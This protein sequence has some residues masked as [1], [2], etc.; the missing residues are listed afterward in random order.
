VLLELRRTK[1]DSLL[2]AGDLDAAVTELRELW[3]EVVAAPIDHDRIRP[4]A[5]ID[6]VWV[7]IILGLDAEVSSLAD[8]LCG[9]P[10]GEVAGWCAR[11][12]V[13]ARAHG[14]A[15]SASHLLRAA[16]ASTAQGVPLVDNDVTVVA[17]VRALELGEAERACRLLACL[18]GGARSPGSYQ[19]LRHA[20]ERVRARLDH[21]VIAGIRAETR[22]EDPSVI[23]GA[24]LRRL[25]A[26]M[27]DEIRRSPPCAPSG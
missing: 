19:L 14:R 18:A 3:A 15:A 16:A 5:G 4:L 26:E 10:G 9:L 24:E 12:V 20:R 1:V 21:E 8:V 13:A 7:S 25:R 11:A 17:A 23:V 2:L 6:L 27:P 22:N